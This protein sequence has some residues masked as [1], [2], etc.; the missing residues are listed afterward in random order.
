MLDERHLPDCSTGGACAETDLQ[1]SVLI[2]KVDQRSVMRLLKSPL[3][4]GSFG[5]I[6][7]SLIVDAH[8]VLTF[9]RLVVLVRECKRLVRT[10]ECYS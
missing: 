5:D 1:F 6:L 4:E 3:F 10:V 9:L 7:S 2:E 8:K